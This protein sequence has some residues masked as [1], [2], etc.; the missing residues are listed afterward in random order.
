MRALRPILIL[1]TVFQADPK[2]QPY[3]FRNKLFKNPA[4]KGK[5]GKIHAD[6][7]VANDL[8]TLI[9]FLPSP[10]IM[11]M[12][13]FYPMHISNSACCHCLISPLFRWRCWYRS[14]NHKNC[15]Y[16]LKYRRFSSKK[17][18]EYPHATLM[19][20]QEIRTFYKAL[21]A[22]DRAVNLA[23]H[24]LI[25][26]TLPRLSDHMKFADFHSACPGPTRI[27]RLDQPSRTTYPA[28]SCRY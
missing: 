1:R 11:D 2:Q 27:G 26:V 18:P 10:S 3:Q 24:A 28:E 15:N 19:H 7:L 23:N 13:N 4:K 14:M 12:M 17:Y 21:I 8:R 6:Y 5:I 9:K 20:R 16:N 25:M 22:E